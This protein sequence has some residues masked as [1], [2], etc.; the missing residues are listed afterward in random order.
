MKKKNNSKPEQHIHLNGHGYIKSFDRY[1]YHDSI[2][3]LLDPR[4]KIVITFLF[5]ISIV[6]TPVKQI[7]TF[8]LHL[9]IILWLI[10]MSGLPI[11]YVFKR[12]LIIIPFSFFVAIFAPFIPRDNQSPLLVIDFIHLN[13][14]SHGLLIMANAILKSWISVLAVIMLYSTTPFPDILRGL[15][16]LRLPNILVVLLSF[17]F[18]F[19]FLFID[20]F[21]RLK[22]AR[23]ARLS[24]T[25][26]LV[27][28]KS[29]GNIIGSLLV[30]AYE[31]AEKIYKA[32]LSRGFDGKIR[33]NAILKIKTVD[34]TFIFGFI[35]VLLLTHILT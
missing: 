17:T 10:L 22:K 26:K 9:V 25:K 23:D 31:R 24:S 5:I 30:R 28:W 33:S 3:H 32:M 27:Q 4:V 8:I 13:I 7:M 29:L 14:Y 35:L 15:E 34:I 16:R 18:R 12:S 1:S 11:S 6:L 2:I 21:K 19:L 20:E